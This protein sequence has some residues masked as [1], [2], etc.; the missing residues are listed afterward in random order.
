M[1]HLILVRGLPGIGKSTFAKSLHGYE[2][3][4]TDNHFINDKGEYVFDRSKLAEYHNKTQQETEY[5]LRHGMN[6]VVSNTF[7]QKWEMIPYIEMATVY[8]GPFTTVISLRAFSSIRD[9]TIIEKL[10]ARCKHHV[11]AEI[12]KSMNDRWESYEHELIYYVN[13]S[14][15]LPD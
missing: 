8:C 6:V 11:P 9:E 13:V 4:E 14:V 7:S 1:G 5:Y 15:D 12:I 10:A 3:F 2:H